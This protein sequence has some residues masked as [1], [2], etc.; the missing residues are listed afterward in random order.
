MI[1]VK[2][3]SLCSR[4]VRLK[5]PPLVATSHTRLLGREVSSVP[6]PKPGDVVIVRRDPLLVS[7]CKMIQLYARFSKRLGWG[8]LTGSWTESIIASL[9][10]SGTQPGGLIGG[11]Q[12][13]GRDASSLLSHT[14]K[15]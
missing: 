1:P 8:T 7:P 2:R 13:L 9:G 5:Q 14:G 10:R 4:I 3:T 15:S 6:E 11:A 12:V